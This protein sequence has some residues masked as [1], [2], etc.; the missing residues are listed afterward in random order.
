LDLIEVIR[1]TVDAFV[2]DLA[3]SHI[4]RRGDFVELDDGHCRVLAPLTHRLAET[5]PRWHQA[6][7]PWAE[8]VAHALAEI[9]PHAIRKA[10]PLTGRTRRRVA[11]ETSA[12]RRKTVERIALV[13][14]R[15]AIPTRPLGPACLDCGTSLV[16]RDGIYCLACWPARRAAGL[17]AAVAA[18][19]AA[20]VDGEAKTRRG[21]AIARGRADGRDQR[22]IDHGWE[23]VDWER[24]FAP[25]VAALS[26]KE[27]TAATGL[28]TSHASRIKRGVQIP[29]PKHWQTIAKALGGVPKGANT[30]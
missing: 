14:S 25:R 21:T 2:L 11:T 20:L 19:A 30:C 17:R 23:A 28:S 12:S 4:F 15:T 3:E 10:T 29:H 13:A 16:S 22:I 5:L 26:L 18:A 8:Y 7:G 1:P 6:I 27:L 24:N 9:S